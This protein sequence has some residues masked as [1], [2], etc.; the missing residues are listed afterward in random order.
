MVKASRNLKVKGW[1]HC[2]AHATNLH[3][4]T[5]SIPQV[6]SIGAIIRKCKAIVTTLHFKCDLLEREVK[7]TN[8]ETAARVLLQ[9]VRE[10]QEVEDCGIIEDGDEMAEGDVSASGSESEQSS[11]QHD[12]RIKC[13]H[14]LQ[15]EIP[16]RWNSCLAMMKS[17]LQMKKEVDN[18]LKL[19]G[20]YEKCLKGTE[21]AII[22]ELS[23]FLSPFQDFTDLVKTSVTSLSLIQ[24]IRKEITD[25]CKANPR[26]CEEVAVLK[27]VV[28]SSLDKRLPLN[29]SVILATLLD[30]STKK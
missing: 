22:E 6:A 19:I 21:W 9:K 4:M 11:A 25:I 24:L 12:E 14:R 15:Q 29:D 28:Q 3:L 8:D 16:T 2:V 10:V 18:V 7:N 1:Q 17:L 13:V 23:H 30:P 5:D 20:H 26:D 27:Q